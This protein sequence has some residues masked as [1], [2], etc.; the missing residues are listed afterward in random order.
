M[1]NNQTLA[2]ELTKLALPTEHSIR[3]KTV[4]DVYKA[5]LNELNA[6]DDANK[7][8]WLAKRQEILNELKNNKQ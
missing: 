8:A 3:P 6:T 2:L 1:T 4:V 7:Q 5:I